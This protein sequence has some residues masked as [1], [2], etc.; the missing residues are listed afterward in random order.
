M[1][2]MNSHPAST[3]NFEI[4][5]GSIVRRTMR[6]V[7]AGLLIGFCLIVLLGLTLIAAG[8]TQAG[9]RSLFKMVQAA[10][11]GDLIISGVSGRLVDTFQIDELSYQSKK[12]KLGA[13]GLALSWHPRALFSGKVEV[14]SL[15]IVSL[16][17]ATPV[18]PAPAQLPADL[19]LPVQLSLKHVALGRLTLATLQ[20][21]GAPLPVLELNALSAELTSNRVQHQIRMDLSSPWGR[22]HLQGRIAS[23][24]PFALQG[25]FAYQGQVNPAV[26]NMGLRGDLH[27]SLDAIAIEAK[28]ISEPAKASP[29]LRL[30]GGFSALV[31]VFSPQILRSLQ[32]NLS[33]LN[34]ADFY[35]GAVQADLQI[36]ADLQA[37]KRQKGSSQSDLTG[38]LYI[39]NALAGRIDQQHL[40]LLSLRSDLDYSDTLLALK[41]TQIQ[42]TGNGR[43]QGAATIKMPKS[44]LP[45]PIVSSR[46]VLSGVDLRQLD[47]RLQT[48]KI[49][50]VLEAQS[51][52]DKQLKLQAQLHDPR[53]SL[54]LE[55]SYPLD[56][57][58][59][60][61]V[62][63]LSRLELLAERSRLSGHGEIRLSQ[64]REF[65]FQGELREFNPA[66]WLQ[67]PSGNINA[68]WTLSGQLIPKLMLKVQ[69]P[70]LQ[71]E[72]AGQSLSGRLAA[73]WQ[74]DVALQVQ[75][76]DFRLGRNTLNA[77]GSWG[78]VKNKKDAL[79]VKL[80]APDLG[81]WSQ[82][83]H[84]KL[85]GS[86]NAEAELRGTLSDPAGKINLNGQA[87]VFDDQ[88]YLGKMNAT[89]ALE[90]GAQGAI[91]ADLLLQNV[92][93]KVFS[94]GPATPSK[95]PAGSDSDAPKKSNPSLVKLAEQFSLS[96][97]GRRDAHQI[98]L[99]ARINPARQLALHG[100]G[101][102]RTRS[103]KSAQW[104]GIISHL[105]LGGRPDLQLLG[106]VAL[107]AN[108]GLVRVGSAQFT[109]ELGALAL[110]QFEWTPESFKTRGRIKDARALD[111]LNLFAA[112]YATQYAIEGDLQ[113]D[114]DWDL[115]L[116]ENVRAQLH[117]R[118]QRGDIRI[119]DADGT[120]NPQALGLDD[121]RMSL[122]TGGLIVGTDA[123]RVALQ[124]DAN[125]SRLGKWQIG[126]HSQLRK[127]AG[128]WSLAP[129]A[130]LEGEAHAEIPDLQWLGPRLSPGLALKGKLSIDA[131][132]GGT[133]AKTQYQAQFEGRELEAAFAAEGLLLPNGSL[134]AQVSEERIKLNKLQFSNVITLM[135]K[136]ARFREQNWVGQKGEF[137]AAGEIDLL[138]QS[139]N[140]QAL[141][142]QFPLLQRK[143][144]WLVMSGQANIEQKNKIWT[145][146][147]KMNADGGYFRLPKLPPPG[148]SED[149]HVN[150]RG[151]VGVPAENAFD[152]D[153]GGIQSRIDVTLDMG[154]RFVFVGRGLDT[155][156]AG[157]LRLRGSDSAPMQAN[158]SIRT[159]AGLY[160]GYGQQLEIERGIL[161]FQ[162]P[163]G[164]P[165]LNIRALRKGLPVEAGVDVSGTVAAPQVRLVSEP[166]VPDAEKISWL[167]LGRGSDQIAGNDASVLM[168][169]ASAIFGGDGSRN[170]PRDVVNGLGFDEFSIG[171][172]DNGGA[173]KMPG[174]TVAG[175]T[176][177]GAAAG[178]QVVSVGKRLAPG[179]VL[180]VERGLS[181]ASGALKLSWQLTR[182]VSIIGRAG[183]DTSVD[184]KYT[185][186]FK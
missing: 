44:G 78:G 91:S 100:A 165:G 123:Q 161:N 135:P 61:G 45:L 154:P 122:A 22:M 4:A 151:A 138:H 79:L 152:A 65:K 46:F 77:H 167:V 160:D 124:M 117:L 175:T 173:S 159:E 186:S 185:I 19:L 26:P 96:I 50:G 112:Q 121:L 49:S 71:G 174:Q 82:A 39:K 12:I 84:L 116:K 101:A 171:A 163:L 28:A 99:G 47:R 63:N 81:A 179:L 6:R 23:T 147:G 155:A 95:P 68:Q 98:E 176:A 168:S 139:G 150:R 8:W 25:E 48:S 37:G 108:S 156:L 85:G 40:P 103:G 57:S 72:Y 104:S 166:N 102:L 87:L 105:S 55:A 107:L 9:T 146:T 182:R 115:E 7:R 59:H 67:G 141:W 164:N 32:A 132:V 58:D 118:R 62:L 1:N 127:I 17:I 5:A 153:K 74:Q 31:S 145:L 43:V 14:D 143:D 109:G 110:E 92:R 80:E 16:R 13:S 51:T 183:N 27:G 83:L 114:A 35:A 70:Q 10:S 64:Q 119:A 130:A 180:S 29:A 128:Q 111:I 3:T 142:K 89:L 134:S 90:Q 126:L 69:V 169:A 133:L 36:Q 18:D 158:G 30:Q 66:R 34:P 149:V 76:L 144:R 86:V 177:I 106:P 38:H 11:G 41:S 2:A 33:G 94:D 56:A 137:N 162:G 93:A 157:T 75:E 15:E 53:A 181:D 54:K 178:D 140:I 97:Q 20:T 136:H 88:L 129:E 184:A 148:L 21:N 120:G 73:N 52:A 113:V 60:E 24:R 131:K 172:A 42:L 170:I 125:G